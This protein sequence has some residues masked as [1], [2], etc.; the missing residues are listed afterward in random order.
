MNKQTLLPRVRGNVIPKGN[1][2]TWEAYITIGR[3]DI[4]PIILAPKETA[5]VFLNEESALKDLK[6]TVYEATKVVGQALS[7][8]EVTQVINL[9]DNVIEDV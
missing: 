7:G 5:P 4:E 6:E 2:F 9:N 3:E 1:G 8:K